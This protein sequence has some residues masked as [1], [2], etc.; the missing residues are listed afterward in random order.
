MGDH[1]R[2]EPLAVA[3]FLPLFPDRKV[4]FHTIAS[5]RTSGIVHLCHSFCNFLGGWEGTRLDCVYATGCL[6]HSSAPSGV[7]SWHSRDP[8]GA[9][10]AGPSAPYH[11]ADQRELGGKEGASARATICARARCSAATFVVE[12]HSLQCGLL[13][14]L[15]I[16][17]VLAGDLAETLAAMGDPALGLAALICDEWL[18]RPENVLAGKISWTDY[19]PAHHPFAV[20]ID[21]DKTRKK[22]WQPL[23]DEHGQLYPE[24][25]AFVARV[26]RLGIP[27]ALFEPAR[28]P[29]SPATG[30]RTPRR[31]ALSMLAIS[32]SRPALKLG[33]PST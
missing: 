22:I 20:R 14:N 26:P 6:G 33:C 5:N 30:R 10:A 21:H 2:G 25:E 9:S 3:S 7:A 19:G 16:T 31:L 24:I 15:I 4:A 8:G 32:S 12:R 13:Q 18:Q 28:G 1:R 11:W 27:K 23:E 17:T 29:K